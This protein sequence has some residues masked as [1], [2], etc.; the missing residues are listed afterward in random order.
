MGTMESLVDS[1]SAYLLQGWLDFFCEG[2]KTLAQLQSLW[3]F[4][5]LSWEK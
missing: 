2:E 4:G 1:R 5:F 3:S